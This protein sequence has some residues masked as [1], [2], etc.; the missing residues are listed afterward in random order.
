MIPKITTRFLDGSPH[1]G[2]PI[3][4][5]D[6]GIIDLK[7]LHGASPARRAVR[8]N[9]ER[10]RNILTVWTSHSKFHPRCG[11]PWLQG[12]AEH[13]ERYRICRVNGNQFAAATLDRVR[14]AVDMAVVQP[15]D[16]VPDRVF[17]RVVLPVACGRLVLNRAR[18]LKR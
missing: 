5:G 18:W 16:R 13:G 9:W 14:D 12:A 11:P 4:G 15:D 8:A 7:V 10:R 2:K 3:E 6:G 17:M 1:I